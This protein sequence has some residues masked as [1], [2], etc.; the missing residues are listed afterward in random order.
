MN[1]YTDIYRNSISKE[2]NVFSSAM[3]IAKPFASTAI[4]SVKGFATSPK[5]MGGLAATGVGGAGAY[6][7]LTGTDTMLG[8]A[9]DTAYNMLGKESPTQSAANAVMD[10]EQSRLNKR[11]NYLKNDLP[12]AESSA[13]KGSLMKN[14]PSGSVS[15][16]GGNSGSSVVE[17]ATQQYN[18]QNQANINSAIN[19]APGFLPKDSNTSPKMQTTDGMVQLRRA[20]P[21]PKVQPSVAESSAGPNDAFLAKVMGSYD[22]KSVAD[23]R[24]ADIVR[25]IYKENPNV[26]P[27]QIYADKRYIQDYQN[28]LNRNK[29]R[30]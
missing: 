30:R 4:N 24:R 28:F 3:N 14:I 22:S 15:F 23:R 13:S 19:D 11:T 25:Q 6:N 26:T 27:N 9:R 21:V 17:K 18:T 16:L 10:L 7:Q 12:V 2:A 8:R 29:R 1:R 5:L 20:E